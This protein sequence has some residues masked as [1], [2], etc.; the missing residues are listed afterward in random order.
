[1]KKSLHQLEIY[2]IFLVAQVTIPEVCACAICQKII[3]R[4]QL[5]QLSTMFGNG[6]SKLSDKFLLP[7]NFYAAG[8]FDNKAT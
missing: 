6:L 3:L 5:A 8:F 2:Y 7:Q 4:A 1:M